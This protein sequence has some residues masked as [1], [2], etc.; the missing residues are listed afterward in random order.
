MTEFTLHPTVALVLKSEIRE[1]YC[2]EGYNIAYFDTIDHAPPDESFDEIL[3][4]EEL[5]AL[6]AVPL[7]K[8]DLQRALEDRARLEN[9]VEMSERYRK[10]ADKRC[11]ENAKRVENLEEIVERQN[12]IIN[13]LTLEYG[14]LLYPDL[15]SIVKKILESE[16]TP[17]M[18]SHYLLVT[19]HDYQNL[20]D[21]DRF[22]VRCAPYLKSALKEALNELKKK[23]KHAEELKEEN[24]RLLADNE[25]LRQA[26]TS[27]VGHVQMFDKMIDEKEAELAALKAKFTPRPMSEAPRDG[28]E[29]FARVNRWP[30]NDNDNVTYSFYVVKWRE[31]KGWVKYEG[32]TFENR[33]SD[34]DFLW[35]VPADTFKGGADE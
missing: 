34:L 22:M 11:T 9:L 29:I 2:N 18:D 5:V 28:T 20:S 8:A 27:S 21:A 3:S 15:H 19:S 25:N 4:L 1:A 14:C 7:L 12:K 10:D 17:V 16:T 32:K 23:E 30:N 6:N 33:Y 35:W 31:E 24:E 26:L 13:K